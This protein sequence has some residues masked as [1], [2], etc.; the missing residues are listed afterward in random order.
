M[1]RDEL[2]ELIQTIQRFQSELNDVE[3]K[4]AHRGT[5]QRLYE[6]LSALANRA[7]GGVIV[8]GLEENRAFEVIGVGNAHRIMEDV[9]SVRTRQCR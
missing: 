5:P 1:T 3:V 9:S 6:S 4:A 7:G 2:L 8:L